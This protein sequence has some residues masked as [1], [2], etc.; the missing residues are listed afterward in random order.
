MRIDESQRQRVD[1]A[2]RIGKADEDEQRVD[3]E[4]T[5][6]HQPGVGRRAEQKRA[7]DQADGDQPRNTLTHRRVRHLTNPFTTKDTKEA[8][9]RQLNFEMRSK[10]GRYIEMTMPPTITP[11]M[12]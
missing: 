4:G 5:D 9:H 10:I 12:A 7:D 6:R 11:R 8:T 3:G 2:H 1:D